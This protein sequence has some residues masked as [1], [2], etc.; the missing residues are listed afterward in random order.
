MEILSITITWRD[1][2]RPAIQSASSVSVMCVGFVPWSITWHVGISQ[3][4]VKSNII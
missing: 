1:P 3:I 4:I 2:D